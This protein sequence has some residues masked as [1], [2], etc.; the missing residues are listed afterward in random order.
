[1]RLGAERF[2]SFAQKREPLRRNRLAVD[3]AALR[4]IIK[5][6]ALHWKRFEVLL[7]VQNTQLEAA[8]ERF[9]RILG[10]Q[11]PTYVVIGDR[12]LHIGERFGVIFIVKLET[13]VNELLAC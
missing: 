5:A 7:Q 4:N 13:R 10:V 3:F 8:I 2:D 12:S 11:T 1:M 9:A 6:L